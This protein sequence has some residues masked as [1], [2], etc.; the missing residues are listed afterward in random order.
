MDGVHAMTGKIE[1]LNARVFPVDRRE[2]F[3]AFADPV[4]LAEWWGPDG[5]ANTI[6]A[7]DLRPGGQ[8]LITMTASNGTDFN[9]RWTFADVVEDAFISAR[10]HEPIHDFTLDMTFR[11]AGQA[12]R[13]EWRM[14]IDRTDENEEL[15][16][17]LE[18]ANEQNFDRLAAHLGCDQE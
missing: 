13:L 3:N 17:F 2:L 5:F 15:D 4:R 6:T 10:H 9:N 16:R 7:F 1:I 8:W 14:L 12:A 11:D 18:A